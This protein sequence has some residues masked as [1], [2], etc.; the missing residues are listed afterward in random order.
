M[1]MRYI[2][3]NALLEWGRKRKRRKK[4]YGC[5]SYHP[6]KVFAAKYQRT[7]KKKN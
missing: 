7:K 5:S 3:E 2:T 1:K 6:L 4:E